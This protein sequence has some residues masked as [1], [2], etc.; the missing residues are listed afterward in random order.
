MRAIINSSSRIVARAAARRSQTT[1]GIN[2]CNKNNLLIDQRTTTV[3]FNNT[4]R[5]KASVPLPEEEEDDTNTPPHVSSSN[6]EDEDTVRIDNNTSDV[7]EDYTTKA[8]TPSPWAVFD[9]WGAGE[10]IVEPLSAE[11]ED[12]LSPDMVRIPTTEEESS[13]LPDESSILSSYD[14]LL[15]RKSSV[16][17]GYPYNLMYNH[18]GE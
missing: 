17:F 1:I 4:Y 12:M 16:H 13:T 15:K 5:F 8:G 7:I 6:H 3:F 9:A 14:K 10:G 18:E 11:E 2:N